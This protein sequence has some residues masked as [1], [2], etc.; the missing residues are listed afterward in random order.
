MSSRFEDEARKE[1]G[2]ADQHSRWMKARVEALHNKVSAADVLAE[3]GIR[4]RYGGARP[5][6]VFCPFHGNTR[7]MAAR[8]HPEEGTS[9]AGIWCFGCNKRF[10]AITLWREFHSFEGS[11]G[12]LLRSMERAYGLEVPEAPPE[13][14]I[15]EAAED[16][17]LAQLFEACEHRLK[18]SRKAFQMDGFLTVSSLLERLYFRVEKGTIVLSEAKQILRK[19]LE[20]IGAKE[21]ECPEG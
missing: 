20:K 18:G 8:Y 2:Q 14:V 1:L 11:F 15:E 21:R 6:Q 4:L 7:T 12:S 17:E 19:M 16:Y 3:N 13:G 10:D 9:R 5:E